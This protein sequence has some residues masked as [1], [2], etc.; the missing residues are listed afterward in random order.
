[1]R[2]QTIEVLIILLIKIGRDIFFCPCFNPLGLEQY[3]NTEKL[4]KRDIVER[5]TSDEAL[6]V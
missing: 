1:M 4:I 6:N 5:T 3:N 2:I